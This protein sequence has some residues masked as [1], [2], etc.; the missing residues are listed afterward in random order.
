[1]FNGEVNKTEELI[2][3]LV[4]KGIPVY[5]CQNTMRAN[6]WKTADLIPGV[7]EVPGGVTAA[8]DY[9][10]RGWAVLTP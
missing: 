2:N 1:L 3:K 9:S 8:I 4:A 6:G 7:K 10:L 5:M